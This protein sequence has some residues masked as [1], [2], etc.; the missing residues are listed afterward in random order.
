[1]YLCWKI[2]SFLKW[3]LVHRLGNLSMSKLFKTILGIQFLEW[4]KWGDLNFPRISSSLLY[5][6][7]NIKLGWTHDFNFVW[8]SCSIYLVFER[9]H[10]LIHPFSWDI[11]QVERGLGFLWL[12][13]I[14]LV[15]K[16]YYDDFHAGF[17]FLFFLITDTGYWCSSFI[18]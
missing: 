7:Y 15:L 9:K 16:N 10:Y 14:G 6:N 12:D 5:E 13:C 8:T 17:N 1:M 2:T 3:S 4:L 11:V 18:W